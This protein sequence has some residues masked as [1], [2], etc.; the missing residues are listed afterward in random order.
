MHDYAHHDANT[1]GY[2]CSRSLFSYSLHSASPYMSEQ[3]F[4]CSG[5]FAL[6]LIF[7]DGAPILHVVFGVSGQAFPY[8]VVLILSGTEL[9]FFLIAGTLLLVGVKP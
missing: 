8:M 7:K 9:I 2:F 1:S 4:V 5:W 3:P 6:C